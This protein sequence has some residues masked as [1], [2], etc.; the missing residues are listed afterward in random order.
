M[1]GPQVIHGHTGNTGGD[2]TAGVS[3]RT[4]PAEKDATTG[5]NTV[6]VIC[7]LREVV[8]IMFGQVPRH[9]R[10]RIASQMLP[11]WMTAL[12]THDP[13][14]EYQKWTGSGT[15]WLRALPLAVA[16]QVVEAQRQEIRDR[17]AVIQEQI[18]AADTAEELKA[19][20]IFNK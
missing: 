13:K 11:A 3:T 12:K 15:K 4:S 18:D 2:D 9:A 16:V 5:E 14:G 8:D 1:G 20:P 6:S 10:T 17:Y 19:L 7:T